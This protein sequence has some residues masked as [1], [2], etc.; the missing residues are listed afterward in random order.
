MNEFDKN[1]Q[2]SLKNRRNGFDLDF[3]HAAELMGISEKEYKDYE[4]GRATLPFPQ[5]MALLVKLNPLDQ[6]VIQFRD[7]E[8]ICSKVE[9][10]FTTLSAIRGVF[11]ENDIQ[12]A[13]IKKYQ[14]G[15]Y[16]FLPPIPSSIHQRLRNLLTNLS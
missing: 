3:E 8:I 15:T 6:L 11:V 4:E 14:R 9:V 2:R 10:S 12:E 1:F 5:Q 13:T 7:D 16:H